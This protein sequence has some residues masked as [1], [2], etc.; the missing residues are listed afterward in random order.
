MG[1]SCERRISG[2]L[3][4]NLCVRAG[5]GRGATV[6]LPI[7]GAADIDNLCVTR[8]VGQ[9]RLETLVGLGKR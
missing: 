4:D 6:M 5:T 9:R 1:S 8:L 7:R 2:S 3:I